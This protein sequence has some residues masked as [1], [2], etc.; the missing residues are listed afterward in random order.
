MKCFLHMSH[1]QR[2]LELCYYLKLHMIIVLVLP[3][4]LVPPHVTSVRSRICYSTVRH[5]LGTLYP[6]S[7]TAR[8][9]LV[10]RPVH[11][12][13]ANFLIREKEFLHPFCMSSTPVSAQ[14]IS[15]SHVLLPTLSSRNRETNRDTPTAETE[16]RMWPPEDQTLHPTADPTA[17]NT[18]RHFNINLMLS[19]SFLKSLMAGSNLAQILRHSAKCRVETHATATR[20][21][22]IGT[23]ATHG[24][25]I[26]IPLYRISRG[27]MGTRGLGTRLA[28]WCFSI[29]LGNLNVYI[30]R[31]GD[32]DSRPP[33]SA[34]GFRALGLAG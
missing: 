18:M 12:P 21:S 24:L 4:L 16:M 5:K 34:P 17:E 9:K 19:R 8:D 20:Q 29:T 3:G 26:V 10:G 31:L 7:G 14:V 28:T 27:G 23:K 1:P 13:L 15:R 32:P 22:R 6:T 11:G 30:W 25:P 2:E 33:N